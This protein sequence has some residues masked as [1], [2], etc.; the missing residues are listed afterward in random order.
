MTCFFCQKII[1]NVNQFVCIKIALYDIIIIVYLEVNTLTKYTQNNVNTK[2]KYP[3]SKILGIVLVSVS[4]FMLLFTS[5]NWLYFIKSFF[6]GTFGVMCYPIFAFMFLFG[7]AVLTGRKFVM[8]KKYLIYL[9][10]A[11]LCII[12][13]FHSPIHHSIGNLLRV[14]RVYIINKIG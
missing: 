10:S 5:V 9:I 6:L 4:L 14:Y 3:K 7:V 11:F 8:S 12:A 2:K 1:I 13:I